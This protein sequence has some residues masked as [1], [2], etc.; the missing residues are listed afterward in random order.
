MARAAGVSVVRYIRVLVV[1][2]LAWFQVQAHDAHARQGRTDV[3]A[4][5]YYC[6]SFE[7][8]RRRKQTWTV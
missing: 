8:E 2:F 5:C 7:L 4:C 6:E 1:C 3:L